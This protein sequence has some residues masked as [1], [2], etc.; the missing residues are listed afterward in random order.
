MKN[1]KKTTCYLIVAALCSLNTL[2]ATTTETPFTVPTR[3]G[4]NLSCGEFGTTPGIYNASYTYPRISELDYF[5]SKGLT[6]IRMPFKWERVQDVLGGPIDIASDI[7]KIKEFLQ[8]AQDRGIY[9]MIDMHN[10][11]RCSVNGKSYV[12]GQTENV[13]INHFVD[14]WTKLANELKGFTNIWGYDIMN[15]P[16]DMGTVSW[17]K[18]AQAA[19]DG[20]RSVDTNTPIV[21][22][23]GNWA[24]SYS[25]KSSSDSLKYLVDPSNKIIYQAHCYF[26]NNA[27]GV[28][29]GTYDTEVKTATI[30]T[31]R[32]KP[33]ADWIQANNK[34]GMI[35]E[36]GVP[37]NDPRWLTMLDQAMDYMK[38]RNLSGTYWA[39][40]PWWGTSYTM[41]VE[42]TSIDSNPVDKPQMAILEK[43]G[44]DKLSAVNEINANVV[45]KFF[46]NPVID[47]LS[48]VSDKAIKGVVIYNLLGEKVI[49][50][51]ISDNSSEHSVSLKN[52][53]KGNYCAK[54]IF[55]D[56]T[57]NIEKVIKD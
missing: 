48:I 56:N 55:K 8:A 25:W 30:A 35:G 5:K 33:F 32:L 6:L 20:I 23:G 40:G 51:N 13:T 24:S 53:L 41:S 54:V 44:N 27:S 31:I 43:Y 3:F 46:P 37:G 47:V 19:I 26:D 18:I 9:V 15:E 57:Y 4:V 45:A 34:I 12:I 42:P 7:P 22:E 16:H 2:F 49:E 10:Y 52:L 11:A 14:V 50:F 29:S 36:F 21:V 1:I 38:S 17:F 28:Y 39:A